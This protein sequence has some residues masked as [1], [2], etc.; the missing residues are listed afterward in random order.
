MVDQ[1]TGGVTELVVAQLVQV[2]M[3][4]A[5]CQLDEFVVGG[6]AQQDGV[7]VFE[8]LGQLVEAD[9]FGRAHKREVF[10]VEVDHLPL[11]GE[12][13]FGDVFKRRHAIFFVLVEAGLD[14]GDLEGLEF[15]ANSFHVYSQ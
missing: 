1:G 3:L 5:P 11:A 4:T 10:R 2:R 7:A 15:V 14:A 6:A 12:R 13:A 9:D 8:I